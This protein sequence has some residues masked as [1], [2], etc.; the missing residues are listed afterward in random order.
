MKEIEVLVEVYEDIGKVK[1]ILNQFEYVGKKQVVDEYYYDPKRDDLKPN[2]DNKIY[3][4]L[5]LREKNNEFTITYKD[6]IYE[7]DKWL[8]SNE[9]ETKVESIDI[10]R[11]I[12]AELGLVKFIEI[13]NTKET[14][15]YDKYEIVLEMVKDLGVFMEVEHCTTDDV[16]IKS[17]KN[18]IQKF[19]DNLNISVSNELN[20]GKPEMFIKKHNI[21]I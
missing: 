13:N 15:I 21:K 2:K 1:E 5:R 18:N 20:Y 17:I 3:R 6:D 14:Y 9:Y 19:I 11:K 7:K 10:M 12:L 16:D 4:C 8:Y